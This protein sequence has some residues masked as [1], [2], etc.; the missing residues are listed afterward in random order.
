MDA[1]AATR[2]ASI[3]GTSAATRG[4]DLSTHRDASAADARNKRRSRDSDRSAPAALSDA[5]IKQRLSRAG[6]RPHG[7]AALAR[8]HC[9]ARL[10]GGR[11]GRC[12]NQHRAK[13]RQNRAAGRRGH[14]AAVRYIPA[15]QNRQILFTRSLQARA[16]EGAGLFFLTSAKLL[17]TRRAAG[18]AC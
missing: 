12:E 7:R 5:L 8:R 11:R 9:L 14:A 3:Q 1:F 13:P 15:L 16:G 6:A 17:A 4:S 10:H 18:T 2:G